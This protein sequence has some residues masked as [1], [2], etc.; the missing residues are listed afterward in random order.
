MEFTVTHDEKNRLEAVRAL[1]ILDTAPED[2]FDRIT[3]IANRLFNTPNSYISIIDS[4]RQW[5]KSVDGTSSKE[6]PRS[7][8]FCTHTIMSDKPMVV[9]DSL[10]DDRFKNSPLVRG[11]SKIRFYAGVPLREKN[12]YRVGTLCLSDIKPRSFTEEDIGLLVDLAN[13]AEQELTSAQIATSD[14]LTEIS[15]RRGFLHLSVHTAALCVRMGKACSMALIDLD[16]LKPVN[17]QYGHAAGD[18][19]LK[20]FSRLMLGNMRDSDICGRIGGDEFA[21]FFPDTDQHQAEKIIARFRSVVSQHNTTHS[22][23]AQIEFSCGIV[24]RKGDEALDAEGMIGE[25]DALM[26]E[27]KR[28]RKEKFAKR[29]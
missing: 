20:S 24:S 27:Q 22:K 3:R 1:S 5:F 4:D 13:M 6:T 17:D 8:S 14:H 9:E 19:L 16:G 2:R 25:A 23:K 11:G 26:Y 29:M 15:N 12:G 10:L 28:N 21:V 18:E 7:V